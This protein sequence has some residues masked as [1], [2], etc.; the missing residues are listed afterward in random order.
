[1]PRWLSMMTIS[2]TPTAG[3]RPVRR[4][5]PD[6]LPQHAEG[7]RGPGLRLL[8]NI[9]TCR[10]AGR[11]LLTL[12]SAAR[13]M[14]ILGSWPRTTRGG[15]CRYWV[16]RTVGCFGR[17]RPPTRQADE[18]AAD[19]IADREPP[20]SSAPLKPRTRSRVAPS[21]KVVVSS[22]NA[23]GMVIAVAKRRSRLDEK[24]VEVA[25][26]PRAAKRTVRASACPDRAG[27]R[28]AGSCR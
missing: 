4:G 5:R 21:V 1:M 6:Q 8:A 20:E 11:P 7:A 16:G 19:Q 9:R 18:C 22:A 10:E 17:T 3:G 15:A 12:W 2:P 26:T 24:V 14:P 25:S 13:A 28:R 27:R 23:A